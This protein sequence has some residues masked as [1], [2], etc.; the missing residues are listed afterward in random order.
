[1]K[2]QVVSYEAGCPAVVGAYN[3][4]QIVPHWHDTDIEVVFVLEGNINVSVVYDNFQLSAGEF[5]VIN[6]EDPHLISASEDNVTFLIH[7][8]LKSFEKEYEYIMFLDLMCESFN[9]NSYQLEHTKILKNY[10]LR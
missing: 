4:S 3:V 10:L 2:K 9:V 6:H 7:I 1:M 8:D 5:V